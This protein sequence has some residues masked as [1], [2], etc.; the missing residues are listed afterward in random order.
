MALL[1]Q[2]TLLT[3]PQ[4]LGA[5]FLA[6]SPTHSKL[7]GQFLKTAGSGLIGVQKLRT[8]IIRIGLRH[9]FVF[10]EIANPNLPHL[11]IQGYSNSGSAL[12]GADK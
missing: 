12:G 5:D 10:A 6:I 2:T 3:G 4:L 9:K 8:Q 1:F 7:G 11:E